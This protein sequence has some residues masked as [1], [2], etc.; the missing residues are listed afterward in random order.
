MPSKHRYIRNPVARLSGDEAFLAVGDV[1]AT[2][3]EYWQ[4][5]HSSLNSNIERGKLAEFLVS[6][7]VGALTPGATRRRGP[8]GTLCT[9]AVRPSR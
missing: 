3:L 2:V 6:K 7:A 4:W 5:A 8:T 9:R 1:P